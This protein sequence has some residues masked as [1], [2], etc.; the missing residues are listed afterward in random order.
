MASKRRITLAPL[1]SGLSPWYIERIYG[2]NI[3]DDCV[4]LRIVN[5]VVANA[6]V[7]TPLGQ[8]DFTPTGEDALTREC[9]ARDERLW[10]WLQV[11]FN[12]LE[13]RRS[14]IDVE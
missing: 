14:S 11:T 3:D 7:R 10:K 2:R 6:F 1:D 13:E 12:S 4:G 8:R 5:G 9:P